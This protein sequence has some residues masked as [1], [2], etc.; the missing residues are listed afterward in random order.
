MAK[1]A[2]QVQLFSEGSGPLAEMVAELRRQQE[3]VSN[4]DLSTFD[5]DSDTAEGARATSDFAHRALT[6]LNVEGGVD[7][8]RAV[9]MFLKSEDGA[10]LYADQLQGLDTDEQ[11]NHLADARDIGVDRDANF[12]LTASLVHMAQWAGMPL[13]EAFRL[14]G[15]QGLNQE[16]FVRQAADVASRQGMTTSELLRNLGVRAS[17][18]EMAEEQGGP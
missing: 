15:L 9:E 13:E 6:A 14:V 10:D 17:A 2:E 7:R 5:V 18:I 11:G 8:R 12:L 16:S 4:V 1:S 3:D